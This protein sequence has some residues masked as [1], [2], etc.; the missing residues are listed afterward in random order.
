MDLVDSVQKHRG[1][2]DSSF[3]F[4]LIWAAP[5]EL[6]LCLHFNRLMESSRNR[7]SGVIS[8]GKTNVDGGRGIS[9]LNCA[10]AWGGEGCFFLFS[11]V[12]GIFFLFS[13]PGQG[14]GVYFLIDR[15]AMGRGM[16]LNLPPSLGLGEEDEVSF[17]SA[18]GWE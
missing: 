16:F 4:F 8:P 15:S 7:M 1:L 12:R 2:G 18:L 11:R 10:G 17:D 3:D 14:R 13:G 9:L 6:T 5:G